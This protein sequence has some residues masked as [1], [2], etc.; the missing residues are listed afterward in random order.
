MVKERAFI[1]IRLLGAMVHIEQTF[2]ELEHIVGV[3]RFRS[4]AFFDKLFMVV[5]RREM[6]R[7]AVTANSD[8]ALV[9]NRLP[10]ELGAFL[11]LFIAREFRNSRKTDDFRHLCI[12]MHVR[13]VVI[14]L[15]HRIQ[16]PLVRPLLSRIQILR[17]V[18]EL[19]GVGV[20][21]GHA[22][23]FSAEHL[24]HLG[25]VKAVRN[26][27]APVAKSQ[28]HGL[29]LFIACINVGIAQARVKFVNVVP[30]HPIAVLGTGI[31]AL[32]AE[33]HLFA[34]G[35]AANVALEVIVLG[36]LVLNGFEFFQDIFQPFFNLNV[37]IVGVMH[38]KCTQV[39]PE[40]MPVQTSPVRELGCFRPHARFFVER[41][42]KAVHVVTQQGFYVQVLAFF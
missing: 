27:N 29:S 42:Q 9:H 13:Q 25:I 40:H 6:F 17:I 41:R 26:R 18:R 23:V 35:H 32:H 15:R 10:K 24:L 2:R 33:P 28:E 7:N 19:V 21:F 8:T 22:A 38:R 39:M 16:K 1:E 37:V 36:I 12:R 5:G 34:V 3:A 31:S 4:F 11:V 20:N 30:R 14:A